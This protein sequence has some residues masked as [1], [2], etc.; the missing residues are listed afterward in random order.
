MVVGAIAELAVGCKFGDLGK[1][2]V[3]ALADVAGPSQTLTGDLRVGSLC[4]RRR[5]NLLEQSQPN[6]V[7]SSLS[8]RLSQDGIVV[9]V[10]I[11]RLEHE[12][13]WQLDF[14]SAA[15]TSIVWDDTFPTD[16]AAYADPL[17]IHAVAFW[18]RADVVAPC[19]RSD[20]DLLQ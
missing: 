13:E 12:T 4:L 14:G 10:A 20:D 11:Y 18:C 1:Q 16:T 5:E 8:R 17:A 2:R 15:G 19:K 3:D 6:L 7:T 9:E